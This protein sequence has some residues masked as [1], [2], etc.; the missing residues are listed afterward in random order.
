[1]DTLWI[2]STN[3]NRMEVR[4]DNYTPP[5]PQHFFPIRPAGSPAET[6]PLLLTCT[7]LLC[8]ICITSP[9]PLSAS[10]ALSLSLSPASFYQSLLLSL[11]ISL[12]STNGTAQQAI[13]TL[14]SLNCSKWLK[15]FDWLCVFWQLNGLHLSTKP[16]GTTLAI[17]GLLFLRFQEVWRIP[18]ITPNP[19]ICINMTAGSEN[20]C[21]HTPARLIH[22]TPSPLVIYLQVLNITSPPQYCESIIFIC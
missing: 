3:S 13:S 14:G 11:I 7:H 19:I 5:P 2:V 21:T 22:H 1:M 17:V 6:S 12:A 20:T 8:F 16:D 4:S 15:C 9:S 18:F 10:L